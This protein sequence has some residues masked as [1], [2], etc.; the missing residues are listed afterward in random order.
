MYTSLRYTTECAHSHMT[1]KTYVNTVYLVGAN[2][3]ISATL[4]ISCKNR[5]GLKLW[6]S[7]CSGLCAL[8]MSNI[9]VNDVIVMPQ[10][11]IG[12]ILI[13]NEHW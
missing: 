11:H 7:S 12:G 5:A 6:H 4:P 3:G 10:R 1:V 9:D 8:Y 13:V 2:N